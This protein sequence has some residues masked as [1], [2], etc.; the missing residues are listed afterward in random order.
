MHLLKKENWWVWLLLFLFSSGASQIVLGALFDIFD[1]NAWYAKW[2]I[3]VIG[4]FLIIPF[5]IMIMV[6]YIDI[7]TKV[8]A[9]LDIEG[10]DYYLSPYIW[11]IMLII[12]IIG[13][14]MFIIL[15]I[16]LN[17]KILIQLKK[18]KG[19]GYIK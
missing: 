12:P 10:K 7:T 19:E 18:G 14:I 3:W 2:Y 9:K 5:S 6:L 13:W 8:A 11:I 16:Y 4:L 15:F 1:R 17:I